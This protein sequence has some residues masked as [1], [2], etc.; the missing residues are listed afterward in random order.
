MLRTRFNGS[1]RG[2]N[3]LNRYLAIFCCVLQL[4]AATYYVSNSGSDSNNGTSTGTPW[5]T[6]AHVNVQTF[7]PGDSILFQSGGEWREQL[8]ATNSGSAGSPITFTNYGSGANPLISAAV[9]P[10]SW[11]NN[12]SQSGNTGNLLSA[13]FDSDSLS[14][15]TSGGGSPAL[16]VTE[17]WT[18]S[19]SVEFPSGSNYLSG[20]FAA[21]STLYARE[22][23]Y[24]ATNGGG[25]GDEI[26][27]IYNTGTELYTVYLTSTNFIAYYNQ[28]TSAGSTTSCSLTTTAWHYIDFYWLEGSSTGAIGIKLDGTSC[29]SATGQNTGSSGANTLHAGQVNTATGWVTYMDNIDVGNTGYLGA[30]TP[31]VP[32]TWSASVITSP[33]EV[34]FNR[35]LGTNV[36]SVAACTAPGDWYWSGGTLYVYSTSSPSIAYTSP[37]IEAPQANSAVDVTGNYVTL[38]GLIFERNNLS[39]TGPVI[40]NANNVTLQNSEVRY[41]ISSGVRVGG[42]TTSNTNIVVNSNSI[43]DNQGTGVYGYQQIASLD[44][45]VIIENNAIYNNVGYAGVGDGLQ[46]YANYW[47]IQYNTIY[48]NGDLSD[49]NIALHIYATSNS[50]HTYGQHNIVRYNTIYNQSSETTADGSGIE[51]DHGAGYN[52]IYYNVIFNNTGPCIDIFESNNTSVEQN[53]CYGNVTNSSFSYPSEILSVD[54]GGS[55]SANTFTNNIAYSNNSYTYAVYIDANVISGGIT[56]SHNLWYA[57]SATNW[58]YN[59]S[60]G[61]NLATWNALSYAGSDLYGNPLFTNVIS[62]DLRLQTGSPAIAAGLYISGVSTAN[63]PNIGALGAVTPSL[64][65]GSSGISGKAT[66]Q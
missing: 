59:G 57:P 23:V 16:S 31:G 33:I 45:E 21:Q 8:N 11:T 12:A 63:P 4:Q 22:Y 58:Y 7:N 14:P 39:Y 52:S 29:Y 48:N 56:F 5:Q 50:D 55:S 20:T 19:Y 66:I 2:T 43:H 13:N 35:T 38:S 60:G 64:L 46:A 15:F 49:D 3:M 36:A 24:I 51:T 26:I 25:D 28:V 47:I 17:S 32:N 34:F 42:D 41:G 6:I 54:L 53:S 40:L 30:I 1:A 61:N 65:S 9:I 18:P 62:G 10:S 37:G 27:D 44:N